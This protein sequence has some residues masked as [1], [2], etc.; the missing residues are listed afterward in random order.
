MNLMMSINDVKDLDIVS[1]SREL[2]RD[3]HVFVNYIRERK[4]KRTYRSNE[5]QKADIKRLAKLIGD[6]ETQ[7]EVRAIG[8]SL[9]IDF[10]DH[11]AL[12][13]GFIYYDTEGE[14]MGYTSTEPSYPDNHIEFREETYREFLHYSAQEQ[15]E[16]ILNALTGRYDHFDNEF[17]SNTCPL[18]VLNTFDRSGCA[19]GVIPSIRFDKAR[20]YLLDLL[21]ECNS[22]VWYSTASFIRNIKEEHPFFLIPKDIKVKERW[23]NKGRYGNFRESKERWGPGEPVNEDDPDAFERVEGRY[24]ERFLENI[25]LIMR[26]VDVAYDKAYER[27]KKYQSRYERHGGILVLNKDKKQINP[28]LNQLKAFRINERFL[29]VMKKQIQKPKVTVLPTF[30]IHVES[31]IYPANVMAQLTRFADVITDDVTITLKLNKNKVAAQ[32]IED[33]ELNVISVL[34]ELA[35]KKL[36]QNIETDLN[37]WT[38]HAE[39]FTVFDGFGLLECAESLKLP[40]GFT[41]ESIAPDITIVRQPSKLYSWL[42]DSELV[43]LL[44][45]HP[46]SSFLMPKKGARSIFS[47]IFRDIEKRKKRVNLKRKYSVTLQFPSE[48]LLM[49]IAKEL[50]AAKFPFVL[51]ERTNSIT[52]T[53]SKEP[54]LEE[55]FKAREKEYLIKIEDMN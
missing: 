24:I 20:R 46:D 33:E 19:T 38:L 26:Y 9:W 47:T 30:E 42:E 14:Y 36:P 6:P 34:E 10:I 44:L 35:G 16:R 23:W 55:I 12:L 15:E 27:R 37:E 13:L 40:A 45:N 28:S 54:E 5:L 4:V 29:R 25:P 41:V 1:N 48:E 3:L 17:F 50:K 21:K 53:K 22:G 8:G 32:L 49:G 7:E 11:L 18:S 43:P 31:D 2:R 51:E 39:M 52:F